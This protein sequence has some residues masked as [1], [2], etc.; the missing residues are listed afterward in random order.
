MC[1][2]CIDSE[3]LPI[4]LIYGPLYCILSFT[5]PIESSFRFHSEYLI[6]KYLEEGSPFRIQNIFLKFACRD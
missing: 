4:L 6:E 5:E 2:E 3:F 1:F